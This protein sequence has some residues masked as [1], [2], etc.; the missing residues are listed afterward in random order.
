LIFIDFLVRVFFRAGL[1]PALGT[2]WG[3]HWRSPG[4]V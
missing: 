4:H 2:T 1:G 3:P